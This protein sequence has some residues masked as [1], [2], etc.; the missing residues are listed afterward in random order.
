MLTALVLIV[1]TAG[2]M[3]WYLR[4]EPASQEQRVALAA[5]AG[6]WLHSGLRTLIED[7]HGL[8][9][10]TVYLDAHWREPPFGWGIWLLPIGACLLLLLGLRSATRKAGTSTQPKPET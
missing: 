2:L 10:W 1:P 4:A 8:V 7:W 5:L 9:A 3:V 6:F